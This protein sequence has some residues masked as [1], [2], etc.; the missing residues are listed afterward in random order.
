MALLLL[1]P[2]IC[3]DVLNNVLADFLLPDINEQ[4]IKFNQVIEDI[5]WRFDLYTRCMSRALFIRPLHWFFHYI[6]FIRP[7]ETRRTTRLKCLIK[8][9][10][11]E[12]YEHL[13]WVA[14]YLQSE[15]HPQIIDGVKL[16]PTSMNRRK[17]FT[18]CSI[19]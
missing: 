17:I 5:N 8:Q 16:K 4:K 7:L 18:C 3:D 11:P 6:Y 15:N 2:Y 13:K 1:Q 19:M 14:I 12:F 9:Q 10:S